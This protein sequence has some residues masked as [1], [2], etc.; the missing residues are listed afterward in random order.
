MYFSAV[1]AAQKALILVLFY[2]RLH[3]LPSMPPLSLHSSDLT[4]LTHEI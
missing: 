1:E 3:A 4:D 2:S